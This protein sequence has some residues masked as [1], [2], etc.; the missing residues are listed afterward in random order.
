VG[1]PKVT[2]SGAQGSAR[3]LPGGDWVNDWGS[4]NP[5]SELTPAGKVLLR[6]YFTGGGS[7]RTTPLPYGRLAA[8]KLRAA[9]DAMYARQK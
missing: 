4:N 3:V 1:D 2:F 5:A 8:S 9:M 7:Y 6:I